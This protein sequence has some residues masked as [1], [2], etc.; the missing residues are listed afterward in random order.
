MPKILVIEDEELIRENIL[1]LLAEE[2][3]EGIGAENGEVGL[4]L[5]QSQKPDLILC[6]I[7]MPEMNGYR[8]LKLLR[9]NS[10][11][12]AIPLIFLT[13]K[14]SMPD[15]RV[16]MNLGADDYLIKP[17][18]VKE[19]LRAI[20]A[21]LE[22]QATLQKHYNNRLQKY[23]YFDSVTQ[24]PNRLS[25]RD[26]VA[27]FIERHA[28]ATGLI[29]LCC[30]GIDRFNRIK[31]TLGYRQSDRAL[32]TV[33]QRLLKHTRGKAVIA[34]LNDATFAL[35]L[36]PTAN[37]TTTQETI[38]SLQQ[39]LAQPFAIGNR[40]VFL[41]TS[42]GVAFYQRDGYDLETL[43]QRATSTLT[44]AQIHGG[45]GIEFYSAAFNIG[46]VK[47]LDLEA[48]LRHALDR[49]EF[50][51][52]Y[53]PKINLKTGHITSSE[54]LIRWQHPQKGRIAPNQFLPLAEETGLI[55]PLGEW[56]LGEACRQTKAWHR[57]GYK[58]LHVAVNISSRQFSQGDLRQRVVEIIVKSGLLP[59]YIELELTE[60]S[61]V[62]NPELAARRLNALKSLGI[63]I[64][65]DDFG[66]GYSSLGYLQQFSFDILKIDQC[67]IRNLFQDEKSQAIVTATLEMA[68]NMK[69]RTVAEGVETEAAFDFLHQHGC[70]EVQ[71]FLLSPP[72]PAEEFKKQLASGK[73]ASGTEAN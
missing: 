62:Q 37:K 33:A 41:T 73:F 4:R 17:L 9:Q 34:Y 18:T 52:Y 72:L 42:V 39:I 21:R 38:E 7:M 71:G 27:T 26:R 63:Q 12:A 44:Q 57:E 66:T 8:V 60:S 51:V 47:Q 32:Q 35:V 23:M 50:E 31:E 19:L 24:L 13:A 3:F 49:D 11:T 28:Q 53:Q 25:L 30:L 45:N 10:E 1:E 36:E 29:P 2:N 67:F 22:K 56:V 58:H 43:L 69:L 5:A 68:R 55:V 59:E 46:A 64:A 40:E 15:W 48:D 54:A 70:H 6:D 20:N 14:S 16:G 61:L 65:I